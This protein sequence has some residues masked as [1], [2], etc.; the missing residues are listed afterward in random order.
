MI[1][2]DAI[3]LATEPMDMRA[4]TETALARVVT[5]FGAAQPHCAHLFANRRANRI[6]VLVHDGFGIWLAAR[7]LHQG[8]FFWPGSRHGSQMELGA[9]Q[10]HALVLGLPL[11]KS[12]ARQCD[13]HRITPVMTRRTASLLNQSD[14]IIEHRVGELLY[15]GCLKPELMAES[16]RNPDQLQRWA[17]RRN[18]SARSVMGQMLSTSLLMS[19]RPLCHGPTNPPLTSS[20]LHTG[21][22]SAPVLSGYYVVA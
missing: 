15:E 17:S 14:H 10:L 18:S 19:A 11:A 2:I 6:K 16:R 8:K 20:P 12:R 3:W 5:V 7:R 21:S 4:G 13:F 1:R 22:G 9:E